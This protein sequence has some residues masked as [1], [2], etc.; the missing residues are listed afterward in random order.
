[1]LASFRILMIGL[2]VV[3]N[4][5]EMGINDTTI[6]KYCATLILIP[7]SQLPILNPNLFFLASPSIL[8]P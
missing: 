8:S 6:E 4:T 1:M 5:I 2:A 7:N 3:V